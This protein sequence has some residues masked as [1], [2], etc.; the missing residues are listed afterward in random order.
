MSRASTP[1]APIRFPK[2]FYWGTA[3]S[4]YQIE[5]AWN[6]DGKGE[7]IWDRFTH[8]PG[9]IKDNSNGDVA[10]DH[11]H[12]VR[13]DIA[14]MRALNL[15]S[16]RFS[17]SWPRIQSAGSGPPNQKGLDFYGRLVDGL[18]DA[19]LRP[20]LT[21]YHWDLPQALED[22]GGWPNRDLAGRFADYTHLVAHALGDRV[23]TWNLF[24][25]PAAFTSLGYLDGTHA[26]GRQ[27]ITDFLRATHTVNL[28]QGAAF[29]ALKATRP[30]ARVGTAFSM[31]PCEP[32]S[33]SED[34]Q[35]A[36]ERAHA[37]TNLW[38]LEPALLG[39]YPNAFPFSPATFMRIQQ[40]DM[41][42]VRAPLDFIGINLYYRT[43]ISAPTMGERLSNARYFFLPAK[44]TPGTKGSRTDFEWEV[45][46]DALYS[47][48]MRIT[49][50]YK[51]PAIEVTE[52]GCSYG[53]A[54]DANGIVNDQRRVA[55]HQSYIE[56]VAR[57]IRDGADVRGHHAWSL[58]DN[59]EW[60]YGYRPRFGIVSV[61][62]T[63]FE[64]TPKPSARWLGAIAK[65][66]A[67]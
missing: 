27:G 40:Y 6:E 66:N 24:N 46:P 64:R 33:S 49:R 53:D 57:A 37:I 3:A 51:R 15:N 8:T 30:N 63:T 50:D 52:S 13:D 45:W 20:M 42:N 54:P 35:L 12:R 32:A 21:L 58:L 19:N 16:Y 41:E 62:R 11:Y 47:M 56:A 9:K 5:G 44:M 60:A 25:E 17:V 61:D 36:A 38:F 34:D 4:A 59:F 48:L 43:M 67:L 31:S 29:R 39:K 55:Y 7:S 18:L 2:N 65:E 28:A 23:T 26:P 14:L 1:V 10:C 22:A